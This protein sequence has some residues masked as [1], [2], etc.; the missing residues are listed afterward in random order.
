MQAVKVESEQAGALGCLD[1]AVEI[2]KPIDELANRFVAPHPC[3]KAPEV[4]QR[5]HGGRIVAAP[6]HVAM[7][8]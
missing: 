2:G 3:G 7:R 8:A 1:A 6:R 4:G 5:L